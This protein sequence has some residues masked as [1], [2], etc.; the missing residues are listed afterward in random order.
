MYRMIIIIFSNIV[1]FAGPRYS[2]M[3]KLSGKI[4][5]GSAVSVLNGTRPYTG[6]K[7]T[8]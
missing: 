7:E 5:S 8:R 3:T 2:S 4:Q 1:V 6:T